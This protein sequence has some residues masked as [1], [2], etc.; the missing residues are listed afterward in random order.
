MRQPLG[1]ALAMPW[2]KAVRRMQ[3]YRRPT[4]RWSMRQ[5]PP[6]RRHRR[7]R[8][9]RRSLLLARRRVPRPSVVIR[10]R[11]GRRRHY[12]RR[13]SYR[14]RLSGRALMLPA[15]PA[16]TS[17]AKAGRAR[18][19]RAALPVTL[20]RQMATAQRSRPTI[21]LPQHRACRRRPG[22]RRA[23]VTRPRLPHP[24]QR[25]RRR[26]PEK[27]AKRAKWS[28]SRFGGLA[29][30]TIRPGHGEARDVADAK[31]GGRL[32]AMR[33]LR[34][35]GAQMLRSDARASGLPARKAMEPSATGDPSVTGGRRAMVAVSRSSGATG[36]AITMGAAGGRR[37]TLPRRRAERAGLTP[38]HRSLR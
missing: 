27:V 11:A 16:T 21:A 2:P 7:R 37:S 17:R 5:W 22:W 35:A 10:R 25:Q 28:R 6:G 32:P 38:I 29:V 8:W 19:R 33:R 20:P 9:R 26:P 3:L 4:Q 34:R 12:Q 31:G 14:R 18:A 23:M 30:G 24:W 13:R 36:I 15:L 1:Q